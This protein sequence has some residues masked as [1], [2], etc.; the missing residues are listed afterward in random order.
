MKYPI[1]LLSAAA[2]IATNVAATATMALMA[3]SANA[4]PFQTRTAPTEKEFEACAD[5]LTDLE[6]DLTTIADVCGAA[7][8]P[9]ALAKCIDNI[10]SNTSLTNADALAGCA[11]VRRPFE[12][13]E[14]VV[15][16]DDEF[17]STLSSQVL[18]YCGRSI[19]PDSFENC[20]EGL[21]DPDT[22]DAMVVMDACV[23]VDY[24]APVVFLPTF[25]PVNTGL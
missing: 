10:S 24:D 3:T 21:Y 25:N 19:L 6:I 13:A 12:M 22:T 2:L 7:R 17:N 23:E 4:L 9:K 8:E 16:L 15:S 14:C 1:R 11:R 18:G 20:V 5:I